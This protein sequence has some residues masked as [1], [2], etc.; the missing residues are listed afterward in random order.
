MSLGYGG[1]GPLTLTAVSVWTHYR[2]RKSV[3][4]THGPRPQKFCLTSMGPFVVIDEPDAK[5][6]N[7]SEIAAVSEPETL[8]DKFLTVWSVDEYSCRM[9][10]DAGEGDRWTLLRLAF[11]Q[12][13]DLFQYSFSL[14]ESEYEQRL[15]KEQA[16]P[17]AIH[18][19]RCR[20]LETHVLDNFVSAAESLIENAV[21]PPKTPG[22]TWQDALPKAEAYVQRTAFPGLN[23]LAKR[24]GC[25]KTTLQKAIDNS[26]KLIAAVQ[27]AAERTT[28]IPKRRR[29]QMNDALLNSLGTE[30]KGEDDTDDFGADDLVQRLLSKAAPGDRPALAAM[31]P[32]TL[33]EMARTLADDPDAEFN[34]GSAKAVTDRA[35][36]KRGRKR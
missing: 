18:F 16:N 34:F 11:E 25:H 32:D 24:I 1:T 5:L 2:F 15:V 13:L 33:H 22:M 23:A 3:N 27:R 26:P 19:V 36:A 30:K 12:V 9:Q 10:T 20:H 4:A 8:T 31:P 21:A 35:H 7:C 29:R 28:A 14:A 6:P 17:L